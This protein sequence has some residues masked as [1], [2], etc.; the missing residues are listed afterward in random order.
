MKPLKPSGGSDINGSC[1][2]TQNRAAAHFFLHYLLL[3]SLG[4]VLLLGVL[5][6]AFTLAFARGALLP[7]NYDEKEIA[8]FK[9]QLAASGTNA[10][11]RVPDR[12][13]YTVFTLEG[14]RWPAI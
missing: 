12:L 2:T 1:K 9:Q 8:Q 3:L 7:A 11:P 5:L 13:E 4:T 6:G 14:S 10:A